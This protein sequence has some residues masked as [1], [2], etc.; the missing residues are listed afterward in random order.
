MLNVK[1]INLLAS[2]HAQKGMVD[3]WGLKI[4]NIDGKPI[5]D[6]R[7]RV[8]FPPQHCPRHSEI[9]EKYNELNIFLP[10]YVRDGMLK[11]EDCKKLKEDKP[12]IGTHCKDKKYV[13]LFEALRIMSFL[14]NIDKLKNFK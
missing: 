10:F 4:L 11:C 9:I 8:Q 3:N 6:Y 14:M 12:I 5:Q 2:L 13:S 7:F 1:C